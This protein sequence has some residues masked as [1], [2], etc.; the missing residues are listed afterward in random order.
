M[1]LNFTLNAHKHANIVP[2]PIHPIQSFR[3]KNK[4]DSRYMQD[5]ISLQ[6]LDYFKLI[7]KHSGSFFSN[8][9]FKHLDLPDTKNFKQLSRANS[10]SFHHTLTASRVNSVSFEDFNM[11]FKNNYR[12]FKKRLPVLISVIVFIFIVVVILNSKIK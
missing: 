2:L 10:F 4:F 1:S 9:E 7:Q 12:Y 3:S 6:N 11:N 8:R 5:L